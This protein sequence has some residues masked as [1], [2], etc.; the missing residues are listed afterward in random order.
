MILPLA[1]ELVTPK[2]ED[3][4]FVAETSS[5][6]E[7]QVETELNLHRATGTDITIGVAGDEDHDIELGSFF[8]GTVQTAE[9]S[10]SGML[11]VTMESGNRLSVEPDPDFESWTLTGPGGYRVVCM[12]GGELATWESQT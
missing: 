9:V 2:L 10:G 1:G 11:L 8:A 5:G 6:Y 7:L 4:I 3:F 12:P